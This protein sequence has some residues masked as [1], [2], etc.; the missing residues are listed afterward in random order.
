MQIRIPPLVSSFTAQQL[1][2]KLYFFMY[3]SM[4]TLYCF[5]FWALGTHSQLHEVLHIVKKKISG[6]MTCALCA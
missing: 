2:P 3:E 5:L 6:S 4:H 1:A